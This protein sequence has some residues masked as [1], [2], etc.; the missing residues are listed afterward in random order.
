MLNTYCITYKNIGKKKNEHIWNSMAC[1]FYN[2]HVFLNGFPYYFPA[3]SAPI[4][5]ILGMSLLPI[6]EHKQNVM[7]SQ[8]DKL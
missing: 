7:L 4:F 3:F 5:M 6:M 8:K 2:I 1:D